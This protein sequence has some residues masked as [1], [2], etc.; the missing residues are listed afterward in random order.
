MNLELISKYFIL[1]I[2]YSFGGWVM[3]TLW[4]S[5]CNKKLVDR[6]FLIGPYCPIYGFG[7]ILIVLL[8]NNLS[9]KPVL[10]FILTILLCGCLEYFVSWCME[11]IFKAR[12]WDYSKEKFN[13]NGRV[14]LHNLIAFGLMGIAI[15]YFINP[16]IRY[17]V[18]IIDEK[19]LRI[20]SLI[21]WTAFI[22][23]FVISTIVVYGFRKT[24]EKVNF[25]S[26]TDNTEQITKMV[27]KLLAERSFFHRRF[28]AAYPK[29]EAIKIKMKAIKTK[30]EDVTSDAKVVVLGKVNDAKGKVV[31]KTELIKNSIEKNTRRARIKISVG[32]KNIKE[33]FKRKIGKGR[34]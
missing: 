19:Q 5:W 32:K 33:T 12:W 22:M 6:G 11:K 24:T 3:E 27:R 28:L 1:F 31:E 23:D 17:I 20:I 15:I 16:N 4:V 29:L 10:V 18:D 8:F 13:L 34:E 9:D 2:I 30:I 25:E 7:A 14:C 21:L 26:A